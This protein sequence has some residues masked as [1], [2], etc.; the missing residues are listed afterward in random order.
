MNVVADELFGS[1][2][3]AIPTWGEVHRTVL[4]IFTHKDWISEVFQKLTNTLRSL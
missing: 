1:R 2:A 4:S 3:Q